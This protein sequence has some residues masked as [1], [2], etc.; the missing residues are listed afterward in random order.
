M[1]SRR[2]FLK[3]ATVGAVGMAASVGAVEAAEVSKT[4]P[5]NTPYDLIVLGAG[6][7]G[8]VCSVRRSRPQGTLT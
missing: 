7:G 5:K 2:N 8:L 3:A 4:S 1:N 6:C